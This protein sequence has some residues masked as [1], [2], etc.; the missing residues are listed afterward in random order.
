M[1]KHFPGVTAAS[2]VVKEASPGGISHLVSGQEAS[3][4][5]TDEDRGKECGAG[6]FCFGK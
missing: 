1:S 6:C 3:E 2:A 5:S 4:T